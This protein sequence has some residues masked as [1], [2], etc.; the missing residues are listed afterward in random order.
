MS[1]YGWRARIGIIL[2]AN[3]VVTE[4]ELAAMTAGRGVTVHTTRLV[5]TGTGLDD[6]RAMAART[7]EAIAELLVADVDVVVYGCMSTSFVPPY[8]WET[9]FAAAV[10]ERSAVPCVTASAALVRALTVHGARRV[11][12]LSAYTGDTL[13]QL[14]PFLAAHGLDVVRSAT[15]AVE[16]L[17]AFGRI[18]ARELYAAA[19]DLGADGADALCIAGT[20]LP[21]MPVSAALEADLGIPVVPANQAMLEAAYRALGIEPVPAEAAQ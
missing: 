13:A 17:Q 7:D 11:A 2:P 21:A 12:V 9:R 20:D 8:D 3:N 1:A 4:P 18:D 15:L 14:E 19:R 10:A 6:L 16:D 5:V